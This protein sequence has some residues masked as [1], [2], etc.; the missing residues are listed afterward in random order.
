LILTAEHLIAEQEGSELY[1]LTWPLTRLGEAMPALAR[2]G[3]L[4]A[5]PPGKKLAW[6]AGLPTQDQALDQWIDWGA[7]QLGLEAEP[8]EATYAEIDQ[9][10]HHAGPALLQ[11]PAGMADSEPRFLALV[12]SRYTYLTL[13][14][15]DRS[16]RRV[17]TQVVRS[18]LCA[19]SATPQQGLID[20]LL[21]NAKIPEQRLARTRHA[22]FR[23]LAGRSTLRGFWCLRLTPAADLKRQL[24]WLRLPRAVGRLLI[25]YLGQLLLTLL[26][27]VVISQVASSGDGTWTWRWAWALLLLT[28]VPFLVWSNNAQNEVAVGLGQIFKQRLLYGVLRLEAEETRHQGVGQFL[29]RVLEAELLEQLALTGGFTTVLALLQLGAAFVV[30]ALGAGGWSHALLLLGW[31][32]FLLP[33]G[34]RYWRRRRTW[35]NTYRTM[36]NDLVERMVGHRTRLAQEER[37]AWHA[38]EDQLLDQ[39]L[40]DS[41]QVDNAEAPLK[42]LIARGWMVAGLIGVIYAWLFTA[43][44]PSLLLISL[45]GMLLALQALTNLMTGLQSMI[46]ALLAWQQVGPLFQAAARP[47]D[48]SSQDAALY[49]INPATRQERPTFLLARDLHF[50]YP[51]RNQPVLQGCNLQIQQGDR[52]LLEGPSGG[53]KS[54][55]GALLAGLR[56]PEAGLLLL[57]GFDHKTLGASWRRR[58]VVAPQFHENHVLTGTLAFN[59]LLGRRWPPQLADLADAETICRELGLGDLLDRMPAGLQQIVGESGWQLSHGERSR[60]YIARTLLQVADL[61]V[62]DESFAALDPENLRLAL[63]CVL[64]HAPTLLVIAHP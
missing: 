28:A 17:R 39:Y 52:L 60:L 29:G 19:T 24:Q 30:L 2:A 61:I 58:V 34:W 8:M 9:F 25:S 11:W 12:R 10:L 40:H 21:H 6:P 47:T 63:Q 43:D 50:R 48:I 41:T 5:H 59:L 64:R 20:Q 37:Q 23:E 62:L 33:L 26:A 18:V 3:G 36:T 49:A 13:I 45:G 54:T 31:L 44:A 42:A 22:L 7:S 32:L 15:P 38:E 16:M 35:I 53:G 46:G 1:K 57:W 14:G 55:L 4:V 56:K 51:A 27:W